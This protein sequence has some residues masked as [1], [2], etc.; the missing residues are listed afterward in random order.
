MMIK[1]SGH[2]LTAADRFQAERLQ[3]QLSERQSTAA[4]TA[5]RAAEHGG[6][7][8]SGRGSFAERGRLASD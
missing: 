7:D 4:A 8:G 2:S 5:E 1:L 3:L 6:D